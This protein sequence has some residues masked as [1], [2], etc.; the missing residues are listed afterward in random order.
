[1]IKSLGIH[2]E[3]MLRSFEI[4]LEYKP[5]YVVV[6]TPHNPTYRWG[7]RLVFS[8]PQTGR[9]GALE[10]TGAAGAGRAGLL[11]V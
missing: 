9:P 8:S 3:P 4:E 2:C 5:L 11:C 10:D 6:C 7:N 1:M